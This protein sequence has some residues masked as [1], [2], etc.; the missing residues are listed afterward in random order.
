MDK[1]ILK[2]DGGAMGAGTTTSSV[3]GSPT[4]P[5][6]GGYIGKLGTVSRRKLNARIAPD[7]KLVKTA[8]TESNEYVYSVEGKPICENDLLEWFG[9]DMNKKPSWNGGRLVK[10]EPKCL[11]FPYC[12][13]G[14]VDK[15]IKLI[16]ETKE[17]MCP[18]CY[19]YVSYIA[20]ESG[21]TPE[22]ITEIIRNKYLS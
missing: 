15:P 11:A 9:D 16:G 17:K 21:K 18:H 8:I 7:Y 12:N 19:E 20:K 1:V 14:S 3:L 5:T 6:Y 2:E 22:Y 10:I 13:Q 4:S